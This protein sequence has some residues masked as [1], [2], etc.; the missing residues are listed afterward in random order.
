MLVEDVDT[1]TTTEIDSAE[2]AQR[3]AILKRFK[4]LLT[5]QRDRFKAY[6]NLLDKQQNVIESGSAEDLLTYV[7]IE[8]KIV[9]DIFSIQKVIDPLE[10]MYN[11]VVSGRNFAK[12]PLKAESASSDEVPGIKASLEK[13]KSEAVMRSTKNKELLSKRMLELRQEIKTLRNNPYATG[14]RKPAGYGGPSAPA[15]VDIKG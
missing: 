13:L 10:E 12:M 11:A 5:Q 4:I 6:L 15:L 7:E 3:V 2:L 8:E 14:G 9:A 1:A